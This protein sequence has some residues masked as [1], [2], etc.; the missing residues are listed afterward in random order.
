MSFSVSILACSPRAGG[1]S[2]TMAHAIAEG[3]H[4]AGGQ[5]Q[6]WY[7]R[8]YKILPCTGCGYCFQNSQHS[9]ILEHKDDAELLFSLFEGAGPVVLTAPIFFYHV[10]AQLKSFIDRGQK[11]WARQQVHMASSEQQE[12]LPRSQSLTV[13]LVAARARGDNLFTGTLAS[14][15]LFAHLFQRD[16]G[17]ASLWKGYDEPQDFAQDAKAYATLHDLGKHIALGE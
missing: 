16:M 1:N 6:L 10:P 9:C 4:H 13:A 14:L 7:L 15:K 8:E 3:V 17:E 11:Y 2:D 12:V 5:A